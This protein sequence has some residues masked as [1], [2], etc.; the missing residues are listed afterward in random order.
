[1]RNTTAASIAAAIALEIPWRW[2]VG[3]PHEKLTIVVIFNKR[4]ELPLR[5]RAPMR[6]CHELRSFKSPRGELA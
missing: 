3:N 2:S 6:V 5:R 1:V 4:S